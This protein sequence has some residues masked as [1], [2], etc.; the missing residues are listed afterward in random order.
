[1]TRPALN[2]APATIAD[3]FRRSRAERWG[4]SR[5]EFADALNASVSHAFAGSAPSPR[6]RDRYLTGL[7]V[8]DLALAAACA[9]GRETAW[10]HFV[11]KHRPVLYR[12]ADSLDPSGGA[13]ELADSMY[14]DL[15]GMRGDDPGRRPLFRYFHGRSSLKTWLRA[16][17]AQR[18]VDAIRARR[19]LEPL[20]DDD[21]ASPAARSL[22]TDPDR[23]RLVPLLENALRTA[24]DQLDVKDR[25]RLRS[26][27]GS[28]L[29][30]AQ[31]GRI[32]GEHEG[33]VSRHLSRTRRHIRD[34][35]ERH[36]RGQDRLSDAAVAR[37]FELILEDPGG[38]DLLGRDHE[39]IQQEIRRS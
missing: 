10:D 37:A 12:A 7:H 35:V 13:R 15:Y 33:T 22:S 18:H 23:D 17:L 2:P 26:Y 4:L 34:A 38:L 16:V 29:T 32:S 39:E 30:L 25:L 28:Q 31:I 8:A 9:L 11:L 6:E 14:A 3:L 27:Y 36:L 5:E 21:T 24:I 19:R 20:L 1:M